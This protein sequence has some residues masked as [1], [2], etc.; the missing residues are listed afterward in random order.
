MG[1]SYL[2]LFLFKIGEM[3][4]VFRERQR[5]FLKTLSDIAINMKAF[6][7]LKASKIAL[8]ED[9]VEPTNEKVG[10]NIARGQSFVR[11]MDG[12]VPPW[13]HSRSGRGSAV[14]EILCDSAN[15]VELYIARV[16]T[17]PDNPD[18][19]LPSVLK[20]CLNIY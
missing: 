2:F 19:F 16:D 3:L 5:E 18:A 12:R 9:G 7:N 17:N 10:L 13:W 14:A 1:S 4:K 20:V 8:I 15:P 11:F 6:P